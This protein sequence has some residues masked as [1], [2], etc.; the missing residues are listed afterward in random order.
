MSPTIY[1]VYKKFLP[2]LNDRLK[3]FDTHDNA[4]ALEETI[5]RLI[6]SIE[7]YYLDFD[8]NYK[9]WKGEVGYAKF[10]YYYTCLPGKR[11]Y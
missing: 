1:G 11:V 7:R 2:S 8:E 9:E 5:I 10:K 6:S 3:F 4:V